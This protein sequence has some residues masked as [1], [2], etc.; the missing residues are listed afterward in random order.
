MIIS[1]IKK[2][3]VFSVRAMKAY[4]SVHLQFRSFLT[5]PLDGG[6]CFNSRPV[7][8]TPGNG[9]WLGPTA[10]VNIKSLAS[11]EFHSPDP[12]ACSIVSVPTELLEF[13]E[14]Q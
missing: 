8:S 6:G 9:G 10:G 2:G 1:D 3:I 5:S 11:T 4:K 12:L 13:Q 7:R 14:H